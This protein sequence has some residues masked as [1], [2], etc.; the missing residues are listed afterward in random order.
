[1]YRPRHN[2]SL[3]VDMLN[4]GTAGGAAVAAHRLHYGLLALGVDSRLWNKPN[5]NRSMS[6][7][8]AGQLL[9]LTKPNLI[10]QIGGLVTKV[11]DRRHLKGR[12]SGLELYT[13]PWKGIATPFD[14]SQL[15]GDVLHLHWVNR[16]LDWQSFFGTLP[17]GH[18]VVWTLHDMNPITGGCHHADGCDSFHRGCGNCPQLAAK[19]RG[20]EDISQM[21]FDIKHQ[22]Y[23]DKNLHIVTPSRWL[24]RHAEQSGLTRRASIQTIHNGLD[25]THFR[26]RDKEIARRELGL[27][28]NVTVIGFGAALMDN[29]RKGAQEFYRAV[30]LLKD[31]SKVVCLGFGEQ[32]ELPAMD[33]IPPIHNTGYL[34]TAEDLS[35]VYSASDLFVMPSLGE[36]MPQT[37]IEAMA[38]GTPCVAFSVGGIPEVVRPGKTGLLAELQDCQQ[39]AAQIQWMIDHPEQRKAMGRGSRK[40]VCDEFDLDQQ[41][42]KY[43][44]L[45]EHVREAAFSSIGSR[46]PRIA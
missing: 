45:Y 20:N 36:N 18:P 29:R 43:V 38:C 27:P 42:R 34:R 15:G 41:T 40:L 31:P 10:E 33:R 3:I 16:W 12:P 32:A 9:N 25:L 39:L 17:T 19:R 37:V 5:R 4:T 24:Q 14:R 8:S 13:T 1:M 28:P 7:E 26:P 6:P 22:S 21:G 11:R 23:V 2:R 35:R 44:R 46:L 30:S